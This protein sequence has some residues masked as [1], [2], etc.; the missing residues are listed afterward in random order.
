VEKM[1][2]IRLP[3]SHGPAF[4]ARTEQLGLCLLSLRSRPPA[5][6]S[7]NTTG[8]NEPRLHLPRAAFSLRLLDSM[9]HF[10]PPHVS[11]GKKT[12][13]ASHKARLVLEEMI[14]KSCIPL[15]PLVF[16]SV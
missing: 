13:G 7:G 6:S 14:K 5:A 3:E 4:R 1:R 8:P 15:I 2:S 10:F 12:F 16:S 9:R 11:T